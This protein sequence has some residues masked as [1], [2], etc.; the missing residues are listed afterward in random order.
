MGPGLDVLV[1][2]MGCVLEIS[3]VV[4]VQCGGRESSLWDCAVEPWGQRDCKHKEDAGVRCS[5]APYP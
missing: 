3:V 5:G 1:E 4:S 2:E